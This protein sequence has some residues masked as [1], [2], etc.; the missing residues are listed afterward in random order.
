MKIDDRAFLLTGAA[1]GI[2]RATATALAARGARLA[3]VDRDE[4]GLHAVCDV[5]ASRGPRPLALV[6]DLSDLERLPALVDD[7]AAKLRGLDVLVNNAGLIS[8]RPFAEETAENLERL[9]RVNVLAPMVLAR[10]VVPRFL[11]QGE[12]RIV[13]VGS[14]FGSIGFAW[15]ASYSASKFAV[16][17]FSE[18][19]RRE[20]A[21]TG[22][23]VTY[24]APRATRTRLA[25]VFGR[26]AEATGMH[27]DEPERVAARIVK[28]VQQDAK[29]RYLGFPECVFVRLNAL[30]PRLVDRALKSQDAKARPFAEEAA[31]EAEA[32]RQAAA[33]AEDAL[34]AHDQ[35]TARDVAE[36]VSPS[37]L[38]SH[39]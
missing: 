26:M 6:A 23:G 13:N 20:L 5:L 22:V 28:A 38:F 35:L 3:L 18:A 36:V 17:G 14:I 2:G 4:D 21:G 32:R 15:F 19:L 27:L 9:Q 31:L 25:D 10:A 11:S 37:P 12:G 39:R 34:A 24:V 29:D 8:F 33:R 1:S 7:A 30:L 16:R